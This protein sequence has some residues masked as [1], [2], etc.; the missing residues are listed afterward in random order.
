MQQIVKLSAPF[1]T[2]A[3]VLVYADSDCA[4]IR[5]FTVNHVI[6]DEAVRL[7][8]IP[9]DGRY[10]THFRW[11]RRAAQLLGLPP[12]DYFGSDYIAPLVSWRRDLVLRL[13]ARLQDI[14]GRAWQVP[15]CRGLHFSEYILYGIFVEHVLEPPTGHWFD[16]ESLCRVAWSGQIGNDEDL[17][18]FF[19]SIKPQQVAIQIQSNLGI[20]ASRYESL[21]HQIQNGG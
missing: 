18:A 2:E 14:A 1:A 20:E 19:A 21:L 11:H 5:P 9:G 4:F 15:L 3:D 13:H 8:R 16:A 12:K 7:L 10:E 17:V 6:R